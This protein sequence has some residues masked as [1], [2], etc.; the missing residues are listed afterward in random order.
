MNEKLLYAQTFSPT[1]FIKTDHHLIAQNGAGWYTV[2]NNSHDEQ[3]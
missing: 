2:G 3:T 1:F